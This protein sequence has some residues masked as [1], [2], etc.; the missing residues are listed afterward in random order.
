MP[1]VQLLAVRVRLPHVI[2]QL[3][4]VRISGPA[5]QPRNW[6]RWRSLF[7]PGA[8]LIPTAV[9]QNGPPVTRVLSPEDYVTQAGPRLEK[10]G[11]YE[12]EIARKVER[13]GHI[14]HVFSTYESRRQKDDEKPFARGI[15]SFQLFWDGARWWIVTIYWDAERPDQPLPAEYLPRK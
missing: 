1:V 10:D 5:A 13:Y 11:F 15:N 8:R 2:A 9:P 12:R 4:D 6:D 7:V 14:A 3:G